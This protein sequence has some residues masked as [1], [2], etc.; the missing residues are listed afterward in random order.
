MDYIVKMRNPISGVVTA[1]K[2]SAE[3]RIDLQLG[4]DFWEH[5]AGFEIVEIKE[6]ENASNINH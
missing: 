1:F 3:D 5:D 6:V 4:L 2:T